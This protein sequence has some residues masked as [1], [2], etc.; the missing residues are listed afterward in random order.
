MFKYAILYTNIAS[1]SIRRTHIGM[2][3]RHIS[4]LFAIFAFQI[5][6]AGPVRPGTYSITQPDGTR[7]EAVYMGDE[8]MKIKTTADGH[9]ITMDEEGWWCYAEYDQSGRIY[10][11]GY[12]VG[13]TTPQNILSS[14]SRIPYRTLAS[15]AREKRRSVVIRDEV[16]I[17]ER[18]MKDRQSETKVDGPETK[19]G[20]VILAEYSDVKFRYSEE[21][22][23]AML[24]QDGYNLNGATGCAKEYFDDQFHGKIEFDFDV[25]SIVTLSNRRAYYGANDN[26]GSDRR[27]AE[28]VVEACRL[29]SE[30]GTDFSIYDDDNDGYVDNVF[31]FFAGEDE[32]EPGSDED[33]IW[34]HAW[35]ISSGAGLEELVLNGKIID[36]YA[37]TAELASNDQL[38]AIG[39]F[40][41]EYSHTF[42]LPDFYDTDYEES[43]GWAAG[44]WSRT[45]LMD[46]GNYN[47]MSNTPP[48]FNSIEREILGL[49]EPE[50]IIR[51]GTY[52]MEPLHKGGKYYRLNTDND[53]EYYL[54]ECRANEGW[55]SY[56]GGSG[57]LVYH[58]DKSSKNKWKYYNTVNVDPYH[59][60]A[61][62]IEADGRYDHFSNEAMMNIE[63]IFFPYG[64]Q[65]LTPESNPGLKFWSGKKCE[66]S[67]TNI[68]S[69]N[70]NISFSV[71]GFEGAAPPRARNLEVEAFMDAAIIRFES[72]RPYMGEATVTWGR[73]GQEGTTVKVLPYEEGK[74]SFILEGLSPGNRT[75]SV[76]IR[77][78]LDGVLGDMSGTSFMTSK[79]APVEWPY[80]YIGKKATEAGVV[81]RGSKIA[82]RVYNAND[83]EEISWSFNGKAIG[84]EG[85]G[86]Y[87]VKESGSLKAYVYWAD[88]S[89]DILERTINISE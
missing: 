88:G 8:F 3:F 26:N 11:T 17:L 29:A 47:N 74:Y 22:F 68:T 4:T 27:A 31:V 14:S 9:A 71:T 58:I 52:T 2:K 12:R 89:M 57:M 61:D 38:A 5:T 39:A 82:L 10:S 79:A 64:A 49:S 60:C 56:I 75:Y 59:Q 15:L 41:H 19:H 32:A 21:D 69:T 36:R 1:F 44:L 45:S 53:D 42:G 83:A 30:A 37:C 16:P 34:S 62:L 84:P 55:D 77:F 6:F 40:C 67:I 86:Y 20:I 76:N 66:I 28:M 70:G 23:R 24:M 73:T 33:C 50:V 81:K 54:F 51:N 43:G 63:G 13:Q 7:F 46:A 25:S 85:D 35:F 78:E 87:T 80:I 18:I 48:Y 72:D 65:H